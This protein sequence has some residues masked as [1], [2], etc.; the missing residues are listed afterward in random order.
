MTGIETTGYYIDP[1]TA[2]TP[3]TLN[4]LTV[5]TTGAAATMPAFGQPLNIN[6]TNFYRER[7]VQLGARFRF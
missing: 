2:T 3:P 6:A 5:G 4:Y 7:Q 1:G